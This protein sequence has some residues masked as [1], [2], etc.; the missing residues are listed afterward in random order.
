[1]T[2]TGVELWDAPV[3]GKMLQE[4]RDDASF[5]ERVADVVW[6]V[7]SARVDGV[8][9]AGGGASDIIRA[10]IAARGMACTVSSDPFAAARAGAARAGACADLGQSSIKLVAGGVERRIARDFGR[11]PFRD[12]VPS[13]QRHAARASTIA[14]IAEILRGHPRVLVALPCEIAGDGVPRGC[15]Y[16][17]RDPDPELVGELA[18]A[19]GAELEIVNDAV[20]A[21]MAV[22]SRSGTWAVV[23]I[24]FGVGGALIATPRA[25]TD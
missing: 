19:S 5:P 4:W 9:V 24:G 20:L 16:C 10:A 13:S 14:A 18:R 21:A 7:F 22:P 2:I 12:A 3:A 17:W 11:M 25:N 23:T 1:V 6:R 8:H 15:S